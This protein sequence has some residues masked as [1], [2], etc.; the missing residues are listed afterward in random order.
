VANTIQHARSEIL[1]QAYSF[2][3]EPIA[4]ALMA[5]QQ[6]GVKV[7]VILD[8]S[9]RTE[10]DSMAGLLVEAGIPVDGAPGGAGTPSIFTTPAPT[11]PAG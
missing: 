11:R 9:Q 8:K 7:E 1:V 10:D 6:R 3:S 2:T 4:Q 5:S